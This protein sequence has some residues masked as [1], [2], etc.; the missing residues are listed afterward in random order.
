MPTTYTIIASQVLGSS[1]STVTFSSIPGTYTDLVLR[2]SVRTD[3]AAIIDDINVTINGVGGTSYSYVFLRGDGA[4][5]SSSRVSDRSN[6]N[7]NQNANGN[8][9]LS[10]TFSNFELYIP[11][12]TASQNKQIGLFSVQEDNISTAFIVSQGSSFRNTGAITTISLVPNS[13]PNFLTNS[14]FYLYGIKNS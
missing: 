7:L 3:R 13:G 11:G 12:Y 5:T 6:L 14:S 4:A 1:A 2:C 10:N 8:T 9:T